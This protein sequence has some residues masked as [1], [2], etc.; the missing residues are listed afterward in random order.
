MA[1]FIEY[2]K[3]G[4]WEH[5]LREKTGN[6]AKCKLCLTIL[7]VTYVTFVLSVYACMMSLQC[8]LNVLETGVHYVETKYVR[9]K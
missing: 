2:K 9:H 3:D 5:F 6:S 7:H 4:I 1:E 8:I